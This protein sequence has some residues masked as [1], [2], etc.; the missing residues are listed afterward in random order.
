MTE[1]AAGPLH[2]RPQGQRIN[3]FESF[4]DDGSDVGDDFA[5]PHN[6][7]ESES[8][9]SSGSESDE[10]GRR[11]R[12]SHDDMVVD[13]NG[14]VQVTK[15]TDFRPLYDVNFT[16]RNPKS[17][18]NIPQDCNE[19]KDYFSLFVD[20]EFWAHLC[21]ETNRYARTFLQSEEVID[22]IE[23]HPRSRYTK[24]PVDGV[25]V[26]KLKKH[27]G[28]L[29]NMG[30]LKKKGRDDYWTVRRSQAMPYFSSI[31]SVDEFNLISRMLHLNNI[32]D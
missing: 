11:S 18:C 16:V 20:D 1:P 21:R 27:V 5:I 28:L 19:P 8:S 10:D 6:D 23:R 14:W 25:T 3:I 17:A 4:A 31:L 22:W 32:A 13:S 2:I 30:L 26:P 7:L 12:S 15:E 9:D 29:L 24:W